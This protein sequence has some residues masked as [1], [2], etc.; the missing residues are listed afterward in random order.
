MVLQFLVKSVITIQIPDQV[1]LLT[2]CFVRLVSTVV[3]E[4]HLSHKVLCFLVNLDT[5]ALIS[6]QKNHVLQ[7]ITVHRTQSIQP[8]AKQVIILLTRPKH[9][10]RNVLRVIIAV[11]I[12]KIAG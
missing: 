7:V 5:I 1:R 10:A 12:N 11:M 4:A 9:L 8:N 3:V 6:Q 2:A